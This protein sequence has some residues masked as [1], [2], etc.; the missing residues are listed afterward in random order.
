M[1]SIG[2]AMSGGVDSSVTASLLKKQGFQVHGFFMKLPLPGVAE[3]MDRVISVAEKLSI[4]LS[5]VDMQEL[6]IEHVM[7]IFIDTYRMG[8]TPN[9]CII[10]NHL[11]KFGALRTYMHDQ[12][13]DKIATGHYCRI[14]RTRDGHFAV[15]RGLDPKKDQSY[16]LCRLNQEQ[17]QY[18]LMPLGELTKTKVYKMAAEMGLKNVHGPESQDVCFLAGRSVETFFEEQGL[19]QCPGDIVS[20]DGK[21][22]GHHHGL[23]KFTIGQRRG[24]GLPD[25]TPWYVQSLDAVNNRVIVCK[26]EELITS[27]TLVKDVLWTHTPSSAWHGLVQI[28]GRS[29]PSPARVEFVSDNLWRVTF[30]DPQRAVTPGQFAAFYGDDF[31]Y[32]SGIITHQNDSLASGNGS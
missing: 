3:H 5:I 7:N 26:Q 16:F 1:S 2:I 20:S 4:P 10:C 14:G 19:E 13:M 11:I 32:G 31:I 6:F 8:L 18:M 12:G 17:L 21:T 9:P 28:R 25:A 23:W 15:R 27:E 24:L 30:S 22:I 29:L